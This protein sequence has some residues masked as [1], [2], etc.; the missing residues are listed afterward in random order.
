MV[1]NLIVED[2]IPALLK[3][4]GLLRGFGD[5][6]RSAF[7]TIDPR[8]SK[9]LVW[10]HRRF[11]LIGCK[12]LMESRDIASSANAA[13]LEESSPL[14]SYD[15]APL[16]PTAVIPEP[17]ERTIR[18][19]DAPLFH[20]IGTFIGLFTPFVGLLAAM[21][22]AWNHGWF[23]WTQ[24]VIMLIG[25]LL[26]GHGIT[27]GYHRMLTH[28]AFETYFVIRA[29]WMMMGA[30]AVQKSPIEWCATHRKHHALSDKPGDP[31]SPHEHAAGIINSLK[32]FWHAH[33]GWLFN[34][35]IFTTDHVRYVPDLLQDSLAIWIHRT[36]D[37]IWFP[38]TFLMPAGI[39]WAITGTGHGA[40]MGFLWG[41]CVRI[42][43]VQHATF[44]VNSICHMF[45]RQD[46][47]SNDQSKNNLVCGVIGFGEGFHNNHHA[48]P[49]SARHG[50]QWWQLDTSWY[51]IRLMEVT[52]LAWN[53]KL[54]SPEMLESKR[55]P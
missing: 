21:W 24:L 45:G 35:H 13:V 34:G 36:W 46:F 33:T 2:Q 40:L 10:V 26:T 23:D 6:L 3:N 16:D 4:G 43:L 44:S 20:A 19:P 51:V 41:S 37:Y 1:D 12:T 48:F 15:A 14:D 50:L 25:A 55:L 49:S 42:F 11:V 9:A 54:P 17:H 30:L 28:R 47:H 53:V 39:S 27:I 52:G 18:P 29:F 31:H 22:L 32:G 8:R 38:L 7:T 5:S